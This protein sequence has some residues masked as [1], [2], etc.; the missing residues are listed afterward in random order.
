[1]V[2]YLLEIV[3]FFSVAQ[4]FDVM[5]NFCPYYLWCSFFF[6]SYVGYK[7][8]IATQRVLELSLRHVSV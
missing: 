1:M 5:G 2:D 3:F 7:I 8:G 6:A 4:L